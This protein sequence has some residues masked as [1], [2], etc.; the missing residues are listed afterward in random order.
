MWC[1]VC[2]TSLPE[3][4]DAGRAQRRA[5]GAGRGAQSRAKI[6]ATARASRGALGVVQ[7]AARVPTT[8]RGTGRSGDK[9]IASEST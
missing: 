3:V 4:C 6:A 8:G 2:L 5:E 9:S 7:V 1:A